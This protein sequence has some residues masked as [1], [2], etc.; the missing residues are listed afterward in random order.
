MNAPCLNFTVMQNFESSQY[1]YAVHVR[2]NDDAQQRLF[3]LGSEGTCSVCGDVKE[4]NQT[5]VCVLFSCLFTKNQIFMSRRMRS[6][7]VRSL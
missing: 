2:L 5:Q 7:S 3:R 4:F 6:S 1:F